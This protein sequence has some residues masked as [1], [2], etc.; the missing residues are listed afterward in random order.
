MYG[1]TCSGLGVGV[2][3]KL[4]DVQSTAKCNHELYCAMMYRGA[5]QR[6]APECETLQCS[7]SIPHTYCTTYTHTSHHTSFK[8]THTHHTRHTQ[9][10][11]CPRFRKPGPT[12]WRA[13][14][15]TWRW[16]CSR[17]IY[18]YIYIY[19]CVY[20]YVHMYMYNYVYIYTDV[21]IHIHMY[22]H[23]YIHIHTYIRV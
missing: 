11:R 22:V 15:S 16:R 7:N 14:T 9:H 13:P 6:S 19:I 3:W 5:L 1:H 12:A 2:V 4:F 17:Y 8:H 18:I 23:M 10:K 21:C 20:T